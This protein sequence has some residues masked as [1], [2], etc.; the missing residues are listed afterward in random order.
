MM[1]FEIK[2]PPWL[3]QQI[4]EG[5]GG[6][7]CE[8]DAPFQVGDE[9]II[10]EY[11]TESLDPYDDTILRNRTDMWRETHGGYYTGRWYKRKI[12]HIFEDTTRYL[13]KKVK[14][15]SMIDPDTS[16]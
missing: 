8:K 4:A 15:L 7:M 6:W 3:F 9:L 16:S 2:C 5:M 14:L 1:C 11:V 10:N 13:D 12:V